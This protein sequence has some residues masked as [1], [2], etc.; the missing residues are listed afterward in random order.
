MNET[1]KCT[2]SQFY[3]YKNKPTKM[4]FLLFIGIKT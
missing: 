1:K 3:S 2:E 4:G